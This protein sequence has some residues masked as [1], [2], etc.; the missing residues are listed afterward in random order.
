[1]SS[2]SVRGLVRP[3]SRAKGGQELTLYAF[4]E[5]VV[6]LEDGGHVLFGNFIDDEY[7]PACCRLNRANGLEVACALAVRE[8][9]AGN[10]EM[11]KDSRARTRESRE[12][13]TPDRTGGPVDAV[14]V[15]TSCSR[16]PT[17]V[18][19]TALSYSALAS[20]AVQHHASML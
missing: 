2:T 18:P 11:V 20:T 1:M 19:R 16:P 10:F 3:W 13:M 7:L 12:V 6:H 17:E 4:L 8:V 15:R 5:D 9:R 14:T